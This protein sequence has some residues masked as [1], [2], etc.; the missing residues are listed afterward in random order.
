[1]KVGL[2]SSM[3]RGTVSTDSAKARGARQCHVQK[4]PAVRS[5]TCDIG[6]Q[7]STISRGPRPRRREANT[8]LLYRLLWESMTPFGGPVVPDV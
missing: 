5:N 7:L 6:S 3:S 2:T 8:V 4:C 1:M